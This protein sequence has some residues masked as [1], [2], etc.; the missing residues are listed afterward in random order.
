MAQRAGR[1]VDLSDN[2]SDDKVRYSPGLVKLLCERYSTLTDHDVE[3]IRQ[4]GRNLQLIADLAQADVFIDC[5]TKDPN[6]AIVVAEASPCTARSLYRCTVVGQPA[7]KENEPGVIQTQQTGLPT[8][9]TRGLT[10]EGVPVKQSVVPIKNREGRTIGTLIMEQD[11]TQQVRQEEQVEILAET[12]EQLTETLLQVAMQDEALPSLM[13]DGL[14]IVNPQGRVTYANPVARQLSNRVGIP[15]EDIGR[16]LTETLPGG[17]PWEKAVTEK[18]FVG[19]EVQFNDQVFLVKAVGLH[20]KE[21]VVGALVLIRDITEI[22]AKEKELMVKSAVIQEIHHRVKNNLQTI[23]SLLRLQMRRTESRELRKGYNESINR[24]LSIAVV[25]EVLSKEGLEVIDIKETIGQILSIITQSMVDPTQ[26]VFTEVSG[27]NILLP[28][29]QA[30][31]VALIVNELIQ[32][33][34]DHAFKGR[35]QGRISI[36]LSHRE[37]DVEIEV[38]DD[39][40]GLDASALG[41]FGSLGLQIV[42]TLIREDLKGKFEIGNSNGTQ[43]RIKFLKRTGGELVGK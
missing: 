26:Q 2:R 3:I 28:S 4:V 16:W 17:Q 6:V 20:R 27:P 8:L 14:V 9:G 24:I 43:V 37:D 12:A 33:A 40:V 15:V 35:K 31:S 19:Q 34:V 29:E 39:G 10:Q 36:G 38:S 21:Q 1:P 13:Q 30:T 23:A 41:T 5:P 42:E 32:N 7:L 18:G 25:H 22:R 11:I